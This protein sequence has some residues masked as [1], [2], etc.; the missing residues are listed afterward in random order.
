MA[1]HFFSYK[2]IR[3]NRHPNGGPTKQ[4]GYSG[5]SMNDHRLLCAQPR[6]VESPRQGSFII[7]HSVVHK[8]RRINERFLQAR[9]CTPV[10]QKQAP[11]TRLERLSFIRLHPLLNIL[12]HSR[13]GYNH[14]ISKK[15]L[16]H[17]KNQRCTAGRIK[18]RKGRQ[19]LDDRGPKYRV[20]YDNYYFKPATDQV[21][22]FLT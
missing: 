8:T 19:L 7:P 15:T 16:Q 3:S 6:L 12:T 22:V 11:R 18:R 1:F 13:H 17:S 21:P 10:P 4:A 2:D 20:R 14:Y 9:G 5:Q